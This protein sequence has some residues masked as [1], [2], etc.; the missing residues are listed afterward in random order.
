M[1]KHSYGYTVSSP[2]KGCL[3][4]H[5]HKSVYAYEAPLV[6]HITVLKIKG[7]SKLHFKAKNSHAHYYTKK[8]DTFF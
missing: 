3:N 8:P 1:C 5:T 2:Y 6:L 4:I 7:N